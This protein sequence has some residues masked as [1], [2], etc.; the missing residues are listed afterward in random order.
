MEI[1]VPALCL[2]I[3]NFVL[4][5]YVRWKSYQS[6]SNQDWYNL[7]LQLIDHLGPNFLIESY[8]FF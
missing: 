7:S 1:R 4:K 8:T 6:I 5:L 2:A 3:F